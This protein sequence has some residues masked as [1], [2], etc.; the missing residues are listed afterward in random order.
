MTTLYTTFCNKPFLELVLLKI[1]LKIWIYQLYTHVK[2]EFG[3]IY[4]ITLQQLF[5]N[6]IP[7]L[8]QNHLLLHLLIILVRT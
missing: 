7:V 4:I 6:E 5:D 2:F 3:Y 1:I 8:G